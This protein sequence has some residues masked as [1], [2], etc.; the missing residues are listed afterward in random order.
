MQAFVNILLTFDEVLPQVAL[1]ESYRWRV[2][3]TGWNDATPSQLLEV[4]P[5]SPFWGVGQEGPSES[6]VHSTPDNLAHYLATHDTDPV[7]D[8]TFFSQVSNFFSKL[9]PASPLLNFNFSDFR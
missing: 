7:A 8:P 9:G 4:Y 3:L 6:P 5:P 2:L 1:L